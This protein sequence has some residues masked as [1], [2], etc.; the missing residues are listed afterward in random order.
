MDKTRSV[1]LS[2]EVTVC[3][4][5]LLRALCDRY[6]KAEQ[7]AWYVI[8][9]INHPKWN[10]QLLL[11]L[12]QED[13]EFLLGLVGWVS[14]FG[15]GI[16]FQCEAVHSFLRTHLQDQV[17]QCS[18]EFSLSSLSE[19]GGRK[20]RFIRFG[21]STNLLV[22]HQFKNPSFSIK[23][24][25]IS[26]KLL[27]TFGKLVRD[28]RYYF[29]DSLNKVS[30]QLKP[31]PLSLLPA[32][33]IATLIDKSQRKL[34][35]S[36]LQRQL[37]EFVDD[38]DKDK[39]KNAIT[40]DA[41]LT[42]IV[43]EQRA[44]MEQKKAASVSAALNQ[45]T[46]DD[47]D[48]S[49]YPLLSMFMVPLDGRV[50]AS[51]LDEVARYERDTGVEVMSQVMSSNGKPTPLMKISRSKNKSLQK[52]Q[53][54]EF[55]DKSGM[56]VQS[57]V[58][59][60]SSLDHSAM[61]EG[62]KASGSRLLPQPMQPAETAAMMLHAGLTNKNMERISRFTRAQFGIQLF[63][64]K[65]KMA[66]L[67]KNRGMEFESFKA[68]VDDGSLADYSY[69]C[70][71]DVLL[72]EFKRLKNK[73]PVSIDL[74]LSGDHGRGFFKMAVNLLIWYAGVVKPKSI[75]VEVASVSC[76]KDTI[77]VLSTIVPVINNTVPSRS[78]RLHTLA[79]PPSL[80]EEDSAGS[81]PVKC[82]LVGDLEFVSNVLGKINMG[83][84][85]CIWCKVTLAERQS[86]A[87]HDVSLWSLHELQDKAAFIDA[88][89][90]AGRKLKP[91]E[92]LGVRMGPLMTS[93]EFDR[94]LPPPLHVKL[95]LVNKI[96]SSLMTWLQHAID[97]PATDE[98]QVLQDTEIM[99]LLDYEHQ[100]TLL[101][102]WDMDEE[103]GVLLESLQSE[104]DNIAET[105]QQ[106]RDIKDAMEPLKQ[107]RDDLL[108]QVKDAAASSRK[109]TAARNKASTA[110]RRH[111]CPTRIRI[112]DE[113]LHEFS[114]EREKYHGGELVGG[115]CTKLM[116][117][118]DAVFDAIRTL[119]KAIPP[120]QR[121]AND[122]DID[123]LC[124]T[125]ARLLK[126]LDA[127]FSI[128]Y[129]GAKTVTQE[130]KIKFKAHVKK[131]DKLWKACDLGYPVKLH[132]L[133]AH[134]PDYLG[135]GER[136]EEFM[137]QQHQLSAVFESRGRCH[138]DIKK[139]KL[140]ADLEALRNDDEIKAV[141]RE[142]LE[143][144]R[145]KKSVA[146]RTRELKQTEL[147]AQERDSLLLLDDL[148]GYRS[149]KAVLKD[150]MRSTYL[151]G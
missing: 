140:Q 111:Q 48:K 61:E 146:S 79:N 44:D 80:V 86:T 82:Y 8:D 45:P 35:L 5:A 53:V 119:L 124:F 68:R 13:Y 93:F 49:K 2:R 10:L 14:L 41:L 72:F 23:P 89:A 12:S 98:I 149:W 54:K 99:A 50:L 38:M 3:F 28:T 125:L 94:I 25:R 122:N 60:L 138:G 46:T 135:N 126:H 131:I 78:S 36:Q 134:M 66:A 142:I 26:S 58:S 85:W 67:K 20:R 30:Q 95:G 103:G 129:K 7:T 59:S 130:D 141:G 40:S 76:L 116:R 136:T 24:V 97:P 88:S 63:A 65:R 112:E 9:A 75:P 114:I 6:R 74:I 47:V 11:G 128:A 109:A 16:R 1:E 150:N 144:N 77:D 32:N 91:H 100:E 113:V 39:V 121:Q 96:V 147:T 4:V 90:A 56:D 83:G 31:P 21:R 123:D 132:V 55:I 127:S 139:R 64:S 81:I 104:F 120:L 18:V 106:K 15:N 105:A 133:V 34:L 57:V 117:N 19:F 107:E 22:V 101:H 37:D 27:Q 87:S 84:H 29:E 42:D 73:N 143:K 102:E 62:A 52:S 17:L 92:S 118:A 69:R 33:D 51:I 115:S 151:P 70:V 145:Y 108:Q 148:T 71:N 110:L 43:H 137:E